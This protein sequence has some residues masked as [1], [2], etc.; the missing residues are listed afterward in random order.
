MGEGEAGKEEGR[1]GRGRKGEREKRAKRGRGGEKEKGGR[2]EER[3][4]GGRGVGSF[5]LE[6]VGREDGHAVLKRKRKQWRC[7]SPLKTRKA[8]FAP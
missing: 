8:R 4:G 6:E 5:P 3:K 7:H 2:R 1:E